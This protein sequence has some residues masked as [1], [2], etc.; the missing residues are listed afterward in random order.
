MRSVCI[1]RTEQSEKMKLRKSS[2]W[3]VYKRNWQK[4]KQPHL[5]RLFMKRKQQREEMHDERKP[6]WL[7]KKRLTLSQN[8]FS[9]VKLVEF[10]QQRAAQQQRRIFDF[11]PWLTRS[12]WFF[13]KSIWVY[14]AFYTGTEA[15][16][17][18]CWR[19]SLRVRG[20]APAEEENNDKKLHFSTVE[21]MLLS[22]LSSYLIWRMKISRH[23][24]Y[25]SIL[26][27]TAAPFS[28]L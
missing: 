13:I 24:T 19:P 22:S 28:L 17:E 5:F 15:Y 4:A 26:C 12:L 1:M 8:A 18:G 21:L 2:S 6:S 7:V 3:K 27:W 9:R 20:A 11:T 23:D 14:F 25:Y 10:Q 16:R